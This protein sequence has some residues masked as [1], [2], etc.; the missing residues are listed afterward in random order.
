MQLVLLVLGI[1]TSFLQISN[2]AV[3][4]AIY[5]YKYLWRSFV[6]SIEEI[7]LKNEN[8]NT[9]SAMNLRSG[10]E[11]ITNL[12]FGVYFFRT[13][14]QIEECKIELLMKKTVESTS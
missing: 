9:K 1:C 7:F 8:T 2:L 10:G 6:C 12:R 11:L 13:Q 4:Y 14:L 3:K 5:I